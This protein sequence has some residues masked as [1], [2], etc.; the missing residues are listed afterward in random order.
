MKKLSILLVLFVV[1]FGVMSTAQ[2]VPLGSFESFGSAA[3]DT[4]LSR[5]DDGSS[6]AQ[7]LTTDITYFG[8]PY[9]SLHVNNNGNVTF[10]GAMSTFTPFNLTGTGRIL[11]AP[12]FA[13]VDTRPSNGGYVW[14]GERGVGALT[15]ASST[16]NT[17]FGGAFAA[18]YGYVATWDHVGFYD[19]NTNSLNTFQLSLLTDGIDSFAIF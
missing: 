3:G 19:E 15:G 11:V 14:Y 9:S 4:L 2:A 18:T 16:I 10:D 13:D 7:A 1:I 17:A 6:S 5:N 12:Y 8:I